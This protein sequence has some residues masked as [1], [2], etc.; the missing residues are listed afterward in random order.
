MEVIHGGGGISLSVV[1]LC[2]MSVNPS[3]ALDM[4]GSRHL[5]IHHL[6]MNKEELKDKSKGWIGDIEG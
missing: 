1:W 2:G 3:M 4:C 6:L 5:T